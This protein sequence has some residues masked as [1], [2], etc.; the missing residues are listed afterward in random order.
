LI[1]RTL[2]F[3]RKLVGKVIRLPAS[4]VGRFSTYYHTNNYATTSKTIPSSISGLAIADFLK[5]LGVKAGDVVF[6]HSSWENLNSGLLSASEVIKILLNHVGEEGTLA[7]P[8]IPN[9]PQVAGAKFNV[10]RTPSAAGM[11]TEVFRRYPNVKRSINLNHSVCA[12]GPSAEYLIKDHHFSETSWDEN[13]PYYRL[14]ELENAWIIGL[15]V[16]H[17]LQVATS[18]HCVESALWKENKYFRKLFRKEICYEYKNSLGETGQHCYVQ[19]SGQI[20]TPKI[21]KYFSNDELVEETIDGLEVYGIKA[22][23]LIARSIK[24]GKEGK[25][26]YIW[27]I[28]LPWHFKI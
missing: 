23:I 16:G 25:T 6:V 26:M 5:R 7:M 22:K 28:P 2:I 13:S 9:I 15:G 8:A 18:L 4:L 17:R 10:R 24:L 27:P 3:S 1:Y 20:Y 19:R 11:L 21:A 12:L 14:G